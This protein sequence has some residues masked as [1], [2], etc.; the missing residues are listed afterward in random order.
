MINTREVEQ[1][2]PCYKWAHRGKYDIIRMIIISKHGQSVTKICSNL[3]RRLL[4]LIQ[5]NTHEP[6]RICDRSFEPR[7]VEIRLKITNTNNLGAMGDILILWLPFRS[8]SLCDSNASSICAFARASFGELRSACAS[9]AHDSRSHSC[10]NK[11]PEKTQGRGH[12]LRSLLRAEPRVSFMLGRRCRRVYSLQPFPGRQGDRL[13]SPTDYLYPE[14]K[15]TQLRWETNRCAEL[16]GDVGQQIIRILFLEER[17]ENN[18]QLL[19]F[20]IWS[21]LNLE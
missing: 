1:I 21:F 14:E 6:T 17:E 9:M 8:S 7:Q 2:K 20:Q 13:T 16:G 4:D 19:C 12:V 18:D 3:K 15:W 11:N 10:K 5:A